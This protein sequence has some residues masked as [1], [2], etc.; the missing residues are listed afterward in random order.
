MSRGQVPNRRSKRDQ[1]TN[2]MLSVQEKER[3][4]A[5]ADRMGMSISTACRYLINKALTIEEEGE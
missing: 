1:Q 2:F 3:L 5:F 4:H